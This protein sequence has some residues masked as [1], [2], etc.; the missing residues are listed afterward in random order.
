MILHAKHSKLGHTAT[1]MH[2]HTALVARP[3]CSQ[4]PLLV[5]RAQQLTAKLSRIYSLSPF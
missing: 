2:N 5:I 4:K 3:Q 1:P